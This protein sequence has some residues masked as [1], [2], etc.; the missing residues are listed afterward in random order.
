MCSLLSGSF[1]SFYYT[2][3]NN[4]GFTSILRF[5]WATMLTAVLSACR[6]PSKRTVSIPNCTIM[7]WCRVF[8]IIIFN[9]IWMQCNQIIMN[10]RNAI[11]HFNEVRHTQSCSWKQKCFD[12]TVHQRG[13]EQN[14]WTQHRDG[15]EMKII[16]TVYAFITSYHITYIKQNY[17]FLA[18][19]LTSHFLCTARKYVLQVIQQTQ[20]VSPWSVL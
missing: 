11:R 16:S 5:R 1:I 9:L 14:R 3:I 4:I 8:N 17:N 6:F 13:S 7:R 15:E 19:F 12:L 20:Q 18:V 10:N 2:S